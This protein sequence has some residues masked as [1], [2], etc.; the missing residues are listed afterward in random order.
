VAPRPPAAVGIVVQARYRS[1][2][3]PGKVLLDVEG[4]SLLGHLWNRVMRSDLAGRAVVATSDD[5]PE[6]VDWCAA[7]G[8]PV[9]VGPEEDLLTRILGAAKTLDVEWITRVTADNPLTDM[10]SIA[11]MAEEAARR[12][13]LFV[14]NKH[15]LG[16]P[17]GTG[18]EIVHRSLLEQLDTRAT[19]EDAR[20]ALFRQLLG[21]G[22]AIR[23]VLV[24][25]PPDLLRPEYRLTVDYPEDL[26]LMRRI[27]RSFGGHDDFTLRA[28][29]ELLDSRPDLVALNASRREGFV[30]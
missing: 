19:R 16:L 14:H 26:E 1:E 15:R 11:E 9:H 8:V 27:F 5:S 28:V 13:W 21:G 2:R 4:T 17:F 10:P 23:P 24:P 25:A 7:G 20:A 6:I 22:G 3:L 12:G 18:A 30:V 29:I